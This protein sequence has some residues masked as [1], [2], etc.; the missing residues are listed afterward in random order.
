MPHKMQIQTAIVILN[1]NGQKHLETYLPSVVK[2]SQSPNTQVIVADN[3]SDDNSVE[4]LKKQYPQVKLILLDKNYGFAEGYN[5][6]LKQIDAKFFVILNSDVEVT[7]NWLDAPIEILENNADIAA[8]A[9]KIK[10]YLDKSKFEYA[11]ACGGY[12]DK[13]GYPFCRGRILDTVE[14]DNAQYDDTVPIFWASGASLFIRACDFH[15]VGG[16]DGDFFAHM[17]EIDLCWRLKNAGKQIVYCSKSE[18]Y[19]LGG[20]ALPQTSPFKLYLNYRNNLR[21]L[22]KNI[23]ADKLFSTIFIRLFLDGL[24]AIIYLA[25]LNFKYFATVWKA[26]WAFY[27]SIKKDR[28]KRRKFFA[29]YQPQKHNEIFN[30][31]IIWSYFVKK[32]RTFEQL[33]FKIKK[34]WTNDL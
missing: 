27:R 7:P 12:L 13:Y 10:S 23:P 5:R 32:N 21:M 8:V 9:P 2:Y 24:S 22:Y 19:H 26:H 14:T 11:G 16:F 20:G 33:N 34:T 29:K 28:I 4:F 30:K 17:E 18:V 31:S 15:D 1:W 25:K 6:A 3:G